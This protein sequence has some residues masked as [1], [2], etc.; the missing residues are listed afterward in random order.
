MH[1]WDKLFR[2]AIL[3]RTRWFLW[4]ARETQDLVSLC[5]IRGW[6]R[7]KPRGKSENICCTQDTICTDRMSACYSKQNH[8][9]CQRRVAGISSSRTIYGYRD[10]SSQDQTRA[11]TFPLAEEALFESAWQHTDKFK[12]REMRSGSRFRAVPQGLAHLEHQRIAR[13]GL[14]QEKTFVQEVIV[15]SVVFE[16]ARHVN[17]PQP[18]PEAL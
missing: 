18:G 1:N 13:E 11:C 4:S 10:Q 17:D 15:A 6:Y 14:L 8:K 2:W 3:R 9:I 5:P 12:T 16:V 7:V